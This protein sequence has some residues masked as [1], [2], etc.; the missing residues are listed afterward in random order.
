MIQLKA[1]NF[2]TICRPL[3]VGRSILLHGFSY[4]VS[5]LLPHIIEIVLA[6]EALGVLIITLKILAYAH[7]SGSTCL[8]QY[9]N[10]KR[11]VMTYS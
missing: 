4:L 3:S 8:V 11:D 7:C 1:E 5:S 9:F 10:Q 2:W 6:L